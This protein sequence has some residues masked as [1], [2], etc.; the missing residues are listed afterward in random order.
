MSSLPPCSNSKKIPQNIIK[1]REREKKKRK[2]GKKG[3]M[4]YN[5][6]EVMHV[7]EKQS[8]LPNEPAPFRHNRPEKEKCEEQCN[9][10]NAQDIPSLHIFCTLKQEA[11][12]S[13]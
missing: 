12:A 13:R 11:H 4:R 3:I 10:E 5:E 1:K 6:D 9:E 7:T 2:C 8:T